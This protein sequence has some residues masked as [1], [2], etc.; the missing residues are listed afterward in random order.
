MLA[1][2]SPRAVQV[3]PASVVLKTPPATPAAYQSVADWTRRARVRPPTLEGP[4]SAQVPTTVA[5]ASRE[6]AAVE[7]DGMSA[8]WAAAAR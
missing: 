7:Y 6:G 8:R 2:A 4:S 1:M 5:V 3:T